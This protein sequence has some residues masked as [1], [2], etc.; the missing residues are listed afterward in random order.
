MFCAVGNS[1]V[2]WKLEMSAPEALHRLP[3]CCKRKSC[4]RRVKNSEICRVTRDLCTR[5]GRWQLVLDRAVPGGNESRQDSLRIGK[6]QVW[7]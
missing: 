2:E 6:T 4:G 3:G 5:T 7:S 1:S